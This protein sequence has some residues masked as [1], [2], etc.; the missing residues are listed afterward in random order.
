MPLNRVFLS[1]SSADKSFVERLAH[2]L[3]RVNIGVWYDTWEIRVGD[4]LLDKIAQGIESNDFLAII[5]SP[6]SVESEWVKREVN[7]A[8]MKE[9]EQRKAVVLPLLIADCTVPT[10]LKE[11]KYADFRKSYEDGFEEFLF[12]VSPEGD[13]SI[14]RSKNFRTVQYLLSGLASTDENGTSTLN[15]TQLRRVYPYRKELQ[16]FLGTEEKRLLFWS[17][18]A[19]RYANPLKPSFM[20][21]TT[22]IWGLVDGTTPKQHAAW[23]VEGLKGVLF[24]DLILKYSWAKCILGSPA[25]DQLKQAF[26]IR[27]TDKEDFL[28]ALDPIPYS[29]MRAFAI[30]LA[31]DDRTIFDEHFL[32]R[33]NKDLSIAPAI[34]EAT[35]YFSTPLDDGFYANFV[36]AEEPVALAAVKALSGLHRPTAV[37]LLRRYLADPKNKLSPGINAA[38]CDLGHSDFAQELRSWFEQEKSL[39]IRVRLLVA[40]ANANSADRQTVLDTVEELSN[41]SASFELLPSLIRVYG[42]IG[43]DPEGRLFEWTKKW[44]IRPDPIL[45]E[46][47]VFSLARVAGRNSLQMMTELLNSGSETILTAVI[48]A[49]SKVGGIDIYEKLRNFSNHRSILVQSSFYRALLNIRPADWDAYIAL[50]KGQHPLVRLCAARAFAQLAKPAELHNWL[51]DRESDELCKVAADEMLFAPRPFAPGWITNPNSFDSKLARLP[52]RMTD[53]DTEQVW[54]DTYLDLDRQVHIQVMRQLT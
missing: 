52:V 50:A 7:A 4:S 5:L 19:F 46:A 21:I 29:S 41:D 31:E 28:A 34:I 45:C 15:S 16:P 33:L 24:N 47:A 20:D 43:V 2:D 27:Q 36:D 35:A 54:L 17:A 14:R 12:A 6:D 25:T 32:P 26:L 44:S 18:V 23:V 39:E 1:H 13:A 53:L 49:M 38:F 37:T 51:G 40:L 3:E 9:L 42:R 30:S 10:L 22:P 11:K 8:L 48:E